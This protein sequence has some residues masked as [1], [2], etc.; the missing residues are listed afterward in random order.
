MTPDQRAA[1]KILLDVQGLL[2]IDTQLMPLVRF[3]LFGSVSGIQAT[4]IILKHEENRV[5]ASCYDCGNVFVSVDVERPMADD[6]AIKKAFE[7]CRCPHC[8]ANFKN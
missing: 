4:P 2:D 1:I 5:A 8:G 6:F 3:V 7:F